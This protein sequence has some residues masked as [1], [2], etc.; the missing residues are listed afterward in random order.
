M[1]KLIFAVLLGTILLMASPWLDIV[2]PANYLTGDNGNTTKMVV[3]VVLTLVLAPI[4]VYVLFFSSLGADQ[5]KW[6]AGFLGT[7]LG[8]WFGK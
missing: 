7:M 3:Q 4:C 2:V 5:Q 8:F 6:A 1:D